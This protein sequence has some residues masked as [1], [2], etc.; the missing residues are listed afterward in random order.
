MRGL[1]KR[2]MSRSIPNLREQ[3]FSEQSE[4]V[5]TQAM[6]FELKQTANGKLTVKYLN[7]SKKFGESVPKN[8]LS[9]STKFRNST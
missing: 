4:M 8:L 1:T 3:N 9:T 5:T 7:K 6:P 2:G